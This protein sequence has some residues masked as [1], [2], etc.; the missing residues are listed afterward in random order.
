MSRNL[1]NIIITGTPGTGKSTLSE[2]VAERLSDMNLFS[3]SDYAKK[4]KDSHGFDD[5]RKA[6]IVDDEKL[7]DEIEPQLEV[8]GMIIDWHVCDVFPEE[9]ID[10]V[11]VLRADNQQLFD[12]LNKRGYA[13][14]KLQENMDAEIM[15]IILQ[16]AQSA[17]APE[18]IVEL[19][20]DTVE[21]MESNLDRIEAWKEQWCKDQE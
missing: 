20:S 8:G 18:I 15:D 5:E 13:E 16:D 14:D 10:L 11:V 19:H 7:V 6:I 2:Q 1:P 3:V 21:D 17:Y 4:N 12:R 9:L